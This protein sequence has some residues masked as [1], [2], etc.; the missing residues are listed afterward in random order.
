[1]PLWKFLDRA[2]WMF[3]GTALPKSLA[4]LGLLTAASIA[5]FMVPVD[6]DLKGEG[7]LQPIV[8]KDI[9]A[10][11]DGEIEAVHVSS[12]SKVQEG[13][14]VVTMKNRDLEVEITN[15]TGQRNQALKRSESIDHVYATTRSVASEADKL[16]LASEK[17][18]VMQQIE[19]YTRQLNVLL[20]KQAAL[21]R[22]SPIS[23]TVTTWDVEKK[24]VARPV[25]TGQLLI[26]VADLTKD[27]EV[28]VF[29]PEKRMKHLDAAFAETKEDYLPCE[30]I[31]KTD[32]ETKRTGK[33]FREFVHQ[34]AEVHGEDGATVKLRVIPDSMEGISRRPG[35]EVIADVKCGK[36][37]FAW[38][39]LYQPIEVI[40]TYLFF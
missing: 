22:V 11:V 26:N 31:L 9:F 28:E 12:G 30:F 40:R 35:A 20:K 4:V 7:S 21:V 24:L 10:H 23:G 34:R 3:R 5:A 37:S 32:P 29:M 16:Q 39:W 38:V 33:L 1:M 27:W 15:I 13:Q 25:V 2:L 8:Q 14:P 17:A 19:N 18:E 6:F 36:R